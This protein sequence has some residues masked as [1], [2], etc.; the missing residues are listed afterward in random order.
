MERGGRRISA[1]PRSHLVCTVL[2]LLILQVDTI[3]AERVLLKNTEIAGGR[4][5]AGVHGSIDVFTGW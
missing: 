4:G 1:F 5:G 2:F 3:G